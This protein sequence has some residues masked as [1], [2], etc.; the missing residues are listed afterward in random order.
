MQIVGKVHVTGRPGHQRKTA[1]DEDGRHNRQAI[2]TISQVHRV[3]GADNHEVRKQ[4]I[5]QPQLRHHVF[6]ERHDQLGSW[7]VFPCQIQRKGHAQ[8]DD[9]HP[10]ILPAGDQAL[11]VF[12]Y[13]FAIVID[14]ANDPVT[15]KNR[16]YTPDIRVGRIRP[17]QHG[18]NDRGQ[19]HDPAHRWGAAFAEVRFRTVVTYNL[20]ERE[21]LQTGNHARAHP[22]RDEQRSQQADNGAKRQVRKDVKA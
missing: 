8:R 22:Q 14:E 9:R 17:Q 7:R 15:H 4:D 5:E 11:G 18:N 16:Q 6:K 1:R 19:D 10:E 20:A 12:A 3:T 21:L 2:Q 13:H